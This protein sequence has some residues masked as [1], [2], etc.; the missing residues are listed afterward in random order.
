MPPSSR[1]CLCR[2]PQQNRQNGP[3][4]VMRFQNRPHFRCL[5][6]RFETVSAS[7]VACRAE[8]CQYL[9]GGSGVLWELPEK[10]SMWRWIGRNS[11]PAVAAMNLSLLGGA[12]RE[13]SPRSGVG[14]RTRNACANGVRAR[15]RRRSIQ[16]VGLDAVVHGERRQRETAGDTDFTEDAR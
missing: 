13:T 2:K 5:D 4:P 11:P 7:Y 8:G 6:F 15:Q 12:W 3:K 14:A 16:A 1:C 9:R 10:F